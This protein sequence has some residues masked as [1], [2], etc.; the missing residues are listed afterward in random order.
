MAA[1]QTVTL[2]AREAELTREALAHDMAKLV[3]DAAGELDMAVGNDDGIGL[4]D[5]GWKVRLAADLL[6]ILDGPL[7]HPYHE[8]GLAALR[9][10][11]S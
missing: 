11:G 8:A 1:D 4:V 5:A 9:A 7:G 10:E 2:T 6:A 3:R